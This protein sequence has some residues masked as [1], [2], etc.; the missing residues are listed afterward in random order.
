MSINFCPHCVP[1]ALT[2]Y[3]YTWLEKSGLELRKLAEAKRNLS[4]LET[5]LDKPNPNESVIR[6]IMRW[7][8]N[9]DLKLAL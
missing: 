2:I 9:F 1:F 8:S 3:N 4:R 6:K 7:A 5:E